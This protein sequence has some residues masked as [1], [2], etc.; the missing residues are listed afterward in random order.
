MGAAYVKD[1]SK[2]GRREKNCIIIDNSPLSYLFHPLNAIGCE[3]WF[4]ATDDTEL[5]DMIPVLTT[6][7]KDIPDVRDLLNANE[8]SVPWLCN[9][10]RPIEDAAGGQE[11]GVENVD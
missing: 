7:L 3:S 2:L 9:Q 11:D 5:R 1:L 6:T 4:G 8:R 10:A